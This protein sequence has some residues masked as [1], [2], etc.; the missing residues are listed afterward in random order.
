M[1]CTSSEV[2]QV[3]EAGSGRTSVCMAAFYVQSHDVCRTLHTTQ[4][5][6]AQNDGR[7][8]PTS[9]KPP[10]EESRPT[11]GLPATSW[12]RALILL[13]PNIA[14][15][16]SERKKC[17]WHATLADEAR[18]LKLHPSSRPVYQSSL[19]GAVGECVRL[20]HSLRV[21]SFR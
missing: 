21:L 3:P 7:E 11:P 20:H 6:E 13:S 17:V 14:P 18:P 12:T 1:Y 8:K 9:T 10:L 2:K 15:V 4:G 19:D 5:T 16:T